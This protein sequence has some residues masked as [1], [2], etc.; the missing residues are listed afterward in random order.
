[1]LHFYISSRQTSNALN[2]QNAWGTLQTRVYDKKSATALS[3]LQL[4]DA[5]ILSREVGSIGTNFK[6]LYFGNYLSQEILL[7]INLFDEKY[8]KENIGHLLQTST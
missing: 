1:M 3:S 8:T 5:E 6:P 7:G 4:V 2:L